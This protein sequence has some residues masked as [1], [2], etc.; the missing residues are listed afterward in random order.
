MN[1][2]KFL[3]Q[4]ILPVYE[5]FNRPP[6][7]GLAKMGEN[8]YVLMPRKIEVRSFIEIG[9]NTI[10]HANSSISA[11]AQ[12]QHEKFTPNIKI[13]NDVYIGE[14][15]HMACFDN[16][17]IDDGCVLSD[18][19]YITDT[20]HGFDPT[21]G[22]I[23]NQNLTSKGG[24]EIGKS[25][26]IGYRSCIMSGVKLGKHCVVGANSVVTKSFPDYSMIA[27]SPARLIKTFSFEKQDWVAV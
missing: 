3:K 1:M 12:Y 23:L 7:F 9:C 16:I 10:I 20:F 21:K 19:V 11:I 2:Y 24:I 6:L 18:H 22:P 17:F 14:Y 25:S 27:G 15:L 5:I 26:F 4:V 8:S 13:G